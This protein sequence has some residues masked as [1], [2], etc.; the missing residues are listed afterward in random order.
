[1]YVAKYKSAVLVWRIIDVLRRL[2]S[3]GSGTGKNF[4]WV[5]IR[6][7]TVNRPNLKLQMKIKKRQIFYLSPIKLSLCYSIL[8]LIFTIFTFSVF[9]RLTFQI[10]YLRKPF[11]KIVFEL[12]LIRPCAKVAVGALQNLYI[13][14]FT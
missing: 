5:V 13:R 7:D 3:C 6:T 2:C 1:M 4:N 8:C 12:Y 14:N 11:Q 9:T 10:I